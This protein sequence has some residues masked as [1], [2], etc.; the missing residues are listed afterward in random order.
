[1]TARSRKILLIGIGPGH[2]DQITLQAIAAMKSVDVFFVPDKGE[3]KAELVAIRHA[4]LERHLPSGSHRTIGFEVPTRDASGAYRAA[5]AAWHDAIGAIYARLFAEHLRD[6]EIGGFLVWGDPSLYD[7]TIRIL[8]A[9]KANGAVAIDYEIIPGITSV[10]QLTAA[11]R[12][13]LNTV[14]NAVEITTG[15]RLIEGYPEADSV[16]VMLDGSTAFASLDRDDLDI[17]W[18]AYLGSGDE[19]LISGPLSVVKDEIVRVRAEAR[20]RKGWM[21]DTYLLRKRG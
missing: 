21:F 19:I 15:R 20:E 17:F 5:V 1:M 2:P 9:V 11:H 8:D 10:Q 16:V 3:E 12:I 7:S 13:A 18:G 6:G 14:G 4:M